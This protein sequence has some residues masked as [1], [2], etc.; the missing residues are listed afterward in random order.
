MSDMVELR[1]DEQT[2]RE[3]S[4][5]YGRIVQR[6]PRVV[7]RPRTADEVA[8]VMEQAGRA[9][10]A[11]SVQGMAHT[12]GGQ[13]LTAGGMLVST[14]GLNR[15]GPLEGGTVWVEAGV[16][17]GDLV[18]SVEPQGYLPRV[19]TS[20]LEVTVGGTLSVGGVGVSSYRYG[21][22]ADNVEELE[23]VT[24]DGRRV[25]CSKDRE[26]ALFDGVRCGLGQLAVITAARIRLRSAPRRVRIY[27]L[28]YGDHESL[29]SDW[30]ELMN[31]SEATSLGCVCVPRVRGTGG[32]R[33][34]Y[35]LS[36]T[37]EDDAGPPDRAGLRCLRL[38]HAGDST[39]RAYIAG[40]VGTPAAADVEAIEPAHPWVCGLL[41]WRAGFAYAARILELLPYEGLLAQGR[42]VLGGFRGSLLQAPMF[43][44]PG[45]P[46]M[47]GVGIFPWIRRTPLAL[48]L[49]LARMR[50]A[51]ELMTG[52]GGKR[53]PS[54]W[55]AYDHAQWRTHY[56]G[57]WPRLLE[58]K[59]QYDPRGML[60]PG[61]IRYRPEPA[62]TPGS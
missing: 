11:V 10:H 42:V 28:L 34:Y 47:L 13:S 2:L 20:H 43:A 44:H 46:L 16:L 39:E 55:I 24:A 15:I 27:H 19:L 31:F 25:R 9:G 37:V 18:R 54:G 14:R 40:M 59:A 53:Y 51:D 45:E 7:V 8:Q 49:A 52:M 50:E 21:S 4:T 30:G 36:L 60:N 17:W 12:Q 48:A 57:Q 5:D 22:Q 56:G 33:W 41:P 58:W 62:A 38:Q 6:T 29:A 3:A 26:R 1:V 23:V 61:F 35:V 32:V